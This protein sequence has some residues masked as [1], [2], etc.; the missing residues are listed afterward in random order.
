MNEIKQLMKERGF[1]IVWTSGD[2]TVVQ[3]VDEYSIFCK[4]FIETK[5]FILSYVTK[6]FLT[7][8][9]GKAGSLDDQVHFVRQYQRIKNVVDKLNN[10]R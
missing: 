2:G 10:V 6:S 5:E 3:Y 1:S 8:S 9:A 4:V 7:I